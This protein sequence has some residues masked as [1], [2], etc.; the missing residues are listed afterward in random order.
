MQAEQVHLV[1]WQG[2]AAAWLRPGAEA[3]KPQICPASL[4]CPDPVVLEPPCTMHARSAS[5]SAPTA[6]ESSPARVLQLSPA[7]MPQ[8]CT[9]GGLLGVRREAACHAAMD[10]LPSSSQSL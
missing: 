9:R 6:Q 5:S 4:P 8:L 1:A 7:R 10:I 2:Q 3:A